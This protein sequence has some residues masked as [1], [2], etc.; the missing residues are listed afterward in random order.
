[1]ITVDDDS[2]DTFR[3]KIWTDEGTVYDNGSQQALGGGSIVIHK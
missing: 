3:M 2:P 1:M